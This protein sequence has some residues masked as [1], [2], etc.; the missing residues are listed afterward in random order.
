MSPSLVAVPA[1][2]REQFF[3]VVSRYECSEIAG[4]GG[5]MAGEAIVVRAEGKSEP[6]SVIPLAELRAAH[7]GFFPALMGADGALA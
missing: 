2:T 3:E 4:V 1:E 5:V 6:I 7:E